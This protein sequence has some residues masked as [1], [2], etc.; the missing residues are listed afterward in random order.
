M[1][2]TDNPRGFSPKGNLIRQNPY[3]V[4]VGYGTGIFVN[5][6]VSGIDDGVIEAASAGDVTIMGS[7]QTYSAAS[8]IADIEAGTPLM[9]SDDPHQLYVAQDDG[10]A[11]PNVNDLFMACNH[12][13]GAGS[14]TT[15][16]SGHEL[17][18]SNLGAVNGGFVVLGFVIDSLNDKTAVN[19]DYVVQLNH[20][21]GILVLPAG[22]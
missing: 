13:A 5:D 9:V 2:N 11:T 12:V 8:T 21:E 19:A 4:A 7:A 16:R 15:L 10:S 20:G 6:V 18:L 17:A 3:E 22:V 14:T 1:A